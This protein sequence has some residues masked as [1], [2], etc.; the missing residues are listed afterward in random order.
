[1]VPMYLP[2]LI[3]DG[4]ITGDVPV[5]F[6]GINVY[7]QQ[8]FKFF[9][10]TPRWLDTFFDSAW[11]LRQAAAREGSTEAAGLGPMTLSMLK[12]AHGNQDK[13]LAR[14]IEWLTHHEKPDI[15]HISNSLLLGLASEL[16]KALHVPLVCTLQDEETWVDD[17]DAPYD[18]LCW[19]AMSDCAEDIDAFVAVS[20]WYGDEMSVRMNLERER[21]RVVPLGIDLENREGASLSFDPPVLG[22]LSKMTD[23]LG[24]G[25][26]VDAF[27]ELK[28]NPKLAKLKLKATGGQ[29]GL[30]IDYVKALKRKLAN[31]GIESDAEFVDKFDAAGRADFL[32]T[33]CVLSVPA[34]QGEAFGMYITEAL[35][36]GVPVVQ[37]D[38][39]GF[40]EVVEATGGGIIYDGKTPGALVAALE[41]LLLNPDRARALGQIGRAAV[42]EKFGIDRMATGLSA[43]Y[44]SL[45]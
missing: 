42:F 43:V 44:E 32:K 10:F 14:L 34:P 28:Q 25:L 37:P 18:S 4:G 36:A 40:R 1:M 41:E 20:E 5:F 13:E 38:A 9:R 7:L 39:G 31:H 15:I 19:E 11:M 23:T 16:K 17:I 35:A 12:G 45:L 22:Y 3:D 8:T 33:L 24:L 6:G 29:L 21:I 30:D 27:I 26:L 2:V